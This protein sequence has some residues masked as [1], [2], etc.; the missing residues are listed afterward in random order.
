LINNSLYCPFYVV[1]QISR[2]L[3][4]KYFLYILLI[5]RTLSLS[6]VKRKGT[7]ALPGGNLRAILFKDTLYK[8]R[9]RPPFSLYRNPA[10]AKENPMLSSFSLHIIIS[11]TKT[12]FYQ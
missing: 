2:A 12:T 8:G 6:V 5:L 4:L 10:M 3:F 11:P 7:Q 1:I 9:F